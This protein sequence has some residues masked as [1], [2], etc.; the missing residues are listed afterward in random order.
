MN[1]SPI[2]PPPETGL[3]L[4]DYLLIGSTVVTLLISAADLILNSYVARKDRKIKLKCSDCCE[5]DYSS[6]SEEEP[7]HTS[8]H[9]TRSRGA[10]D[11]D[12]PVI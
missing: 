6:E 5:F 2:S 4:A 8:A 3:T 12:R 10:S 11:P 9:T 7:A 1:S